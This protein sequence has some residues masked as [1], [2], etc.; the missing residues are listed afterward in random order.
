MIVIGILDDFGNG[1]LLVGRRELRSN[2]SCLH[3]VEVLVK[4]THRCTLEIHPDD[5]GRLGLVD[6][7]PPRFAAV[8]MAGCAPIVKAFEEGAD[9]ATRWENPRT[10]ASGLRVPAAI[11]DSLILSAIRESGGTA[12]AVKDAEM[13]SGQLE[14]ARGEG[15]SPAPEGGATLAA[16]K[17]MVET[18]QVDPGAFASAFGAGVDQLEV[19]VAEPGIAG[20]S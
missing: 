17:H 9:H 12:I 2:S 1:M 13:A 15:I 14:M 10:Y 4:G 7:P 16:L 5:A 11:G 6:G 18:A 19:L 3:N 20:D 8:Q